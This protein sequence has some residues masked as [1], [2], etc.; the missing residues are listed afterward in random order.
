MDTTL[1]EQIIQ[2]IQNDEV[3]VTIMKKTRKC[4][5]L[6]QRIFK[7]PSSEIIKC[8]VYRQCIVSEVFLQTYKRCIGVVYRSSV[9]DNMMSC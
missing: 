3:F 2:V 4:L 6:S 8:I 5:Y 9:Q 7:C 1:S